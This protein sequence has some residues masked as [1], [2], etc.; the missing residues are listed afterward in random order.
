MGPSADPLFPY[1]PPNDHKLALAK[2]PFANRG[3]GIKTLN[4]PFSKNQYSRH[5]MGMAPSSLAPATCNHSLGQ[6]LAPLK[7]SPV[8]VS[9]SRAPPSQIP[10]TRGVNVE[11]TLPKR[12]VH[13]TCQ[14]R[15]TLLMSCV[16][17]IHRM[18]TRLSTFHGL[19][20]QGATSSS[21]ETPGHDKSTVG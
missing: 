1:P 6:T 4:S 16:T 2:A 17:A 20:D 7:T 11:W 9:S 5:Y 14:P 8:E 15:H 3:L 12:R 19:S 13:S 18:K 10:E 21:Y